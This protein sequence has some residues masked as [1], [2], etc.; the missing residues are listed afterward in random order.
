MMS[1]PNINIKWTRDEEL[2]F[3]KEISNGQKIEQLTEKYNRSA[4][5]LTLRLNKIIYENILAGK[6]ISTIA[7]GLNLSHDTVRQHFVAYKDFRE[8]Y[9]GI[10]DLDN[11]NPDLIK[12]T[13]DRHNLIKQEMHGGGDTLVEKMN[14]KIKQL[15]CENQMIKTII[16][17]KELHHKMN[18]MV[19][20]GS[21]DYNVK[22]LIKEFKKRTKK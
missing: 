10:E 21:I 16:E 7:K 12:V 19:K 6:S 13:P 17:N 11:V 20:D 18:K 2:K 8:K 5:S 4:S 1:T 9:K 14:K 3:I 15:D 22:L